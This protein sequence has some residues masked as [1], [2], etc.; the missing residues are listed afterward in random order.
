MYNLFCAAAALAI[1]LP[2]VTAVAGD[3][4]SALRPVVTAPG[5]TFSALGSV[6]AVA[7]SPWELRRTVAG[8]PMTEEF[9][10]GLISEAINRSSLNFDAGPIDYGI[11]SSDFI[12]NNTS[13]PEQMTSPADVG[14][15][16]ADEIGQHLDVIA[17]NG[18]P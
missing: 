8:G 14:I 17:G 9:V 4:E 11:L 12:R 13:T 2:V 10:R 1:V 5:S 15:N 18:S 16:I 7:M 3:R 6:P